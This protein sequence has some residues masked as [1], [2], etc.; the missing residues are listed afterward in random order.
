[1]MESVYYEQSQPGSY[2]GIRPLA[3]YSGSP[4][5]TVTKWLSSQDTYTL[6]KPIRKTFPRRKTFAKGINDLFQADLVEMQSMSRA[7]D[8]YRYI[9]T[10]IDVFSKYAFAIPLKDKKGSTV[11]AAF[12]TI[13]AERTP[14]FLQTDRGVEFLNHQVQDVLRKHDV[15]HYSSLNDDIKAACVERY[16]RTL[17]SRMY[18]YM[19]HHHTNRWVDALQSI[20]DSY[21]RTVHRSI[22]M[23]PIDV[24]V[25]NE[26][27][28]ARRLYPPK[29][30]L[31]WKYQT[32]DRV[33]IG[34]YKHVFG[35]GYLPNW[36]EEIFTVADRHPTFPVTYGLTDLSGEPIKGKFYEQEIQ[37]IDKT[38][39]V[40]QVERVLKT[41]KRAGK[42]EH[43]VKWKGYPSKFNS[44][45]T[46]ILK[47]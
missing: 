18:R 21:N 32:G 25:E 8:G 12:E 27:A 17:K 44:W 38:D 45:T 47:T 11:S 7:N 33:R 30:A 42:L 13:F 39:D 5:K 46:D 19:T 23:P 14:V 3:R 31:S 37:K 29:P 41:R 43:F 20:V 24:N 34:K 2:G 6:H 28:V 15:R 35:K 10:C 22:G 26:D 16:N 36:S 40:Y 4:I 9:L 1:M